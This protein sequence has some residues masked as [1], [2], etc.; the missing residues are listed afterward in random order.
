MRFSDDDHRWHEP[1]DRAELRVERRS[2][3]DGPPVIVGYAALFDVLSEEMRGFRER[4]APGAFA[5]SLDAGD[6]VLGL[7]NH[8]PNFVLGRRSAGT[9]KVAEDDKGLRYEIQVPDTRAGEDVVNSIE[10]GD[11]QGS[12]FGFVTI[13]DDWDETRTVRELRQIALWDVSP[14]TYPAYAAT[15][16]QLGLRS[17]SRLVEADQR[18]R[19]ALARRRLDLAKATA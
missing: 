18:Q 2:E 7:F 10:R 11:I 6:D 14:V 16:G 15:N 4:I 8:D 19:M 13:E 1:A 17:R 12:S 5:A 9:L 3:G